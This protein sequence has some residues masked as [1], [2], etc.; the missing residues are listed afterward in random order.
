MRIL[1]RSPAVMCRSDAPRSIISSSRTRRLTPCCWGAAP[2]AAGG[3]PVIDG[4]GS[5]RFCAAHG[6]SGAGLAE[7][8]FARHHALEDLEPSVHAEREH[9]ILDA[10]FLDLG[11]ADVLQDEA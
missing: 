2:G 5:W 7:D 9:A 1:A 10:A 3:A 8:L 11:G 4:S 6:A